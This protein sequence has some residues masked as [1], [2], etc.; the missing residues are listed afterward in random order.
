MVSTGLAE[1]EQSTEPYAAQEGR[2]SREDAFLVE[3]FRRR[4]GEAEAGAA[5]FFSRRIQGK[6]QPPAEIE[7]D[8]PTASDDPDAA[9]PGASQEFTSVYNDS[10]GAPVDED[11]RCKIEPPVG[12]KTPPPPPDCLGFTL[13]RVSK[14]TLAQ[15]GG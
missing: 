6:T 13:R 5:G 1:Q 9:G 15:G 14:H 8:S 2:S 4:S 11:S 10:D 3:F 12:I 7:T